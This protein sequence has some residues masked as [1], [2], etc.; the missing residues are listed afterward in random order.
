M[1]DCVN[2]HGQKGRAWLGA[3]FNNFIKMKKNKNSPQKR[4]TDS[5]VYFI[6]GTLHYVMGEFG[7]LGN[8]V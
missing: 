5:S 6:K 1:S 8:L 7:R 2:I 3:L 4:L